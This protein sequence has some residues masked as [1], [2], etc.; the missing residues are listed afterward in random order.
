LART[1]IVQPTFT[2]LLVG[3][4]VAI[5]SSPFDPHHSHEADVFDRGFDTEVGC[6][7]SQLSGG[8]K[9]Q[10][11][12]VKCKNRLADIS[13]NL[14]KSY[15]TL[16]FDIFQLFA[17]PHMT[18]HVAIT[19]TKI[20]CIVMLPFVQVISIGTHRAYPCVVFEASDP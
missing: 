18:P 3:F 19:L 15:F 16:D 10:C 6:E 13:L 14:V 2:I 17:N 11:S 9:R 8:K 7:G 1:R 4:L 20:P 5:K 12:V